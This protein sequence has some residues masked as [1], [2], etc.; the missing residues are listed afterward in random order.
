M[1]VQPTPP[2]TFSI[3]RPEDAGPGLQIVPDGPGRIHAR[4]LGRVVVDLV[5][6]SIVMVLTTESLWGVDHLTT[7]ESF[8]LGVLVVPVIIANMGWIGLYDRTQSRRWPAAVLVVGRSVLLGAV[9]FSLA[10]FFTEMGN[11]AR[12]WILLVTLAWLVVLSLHHGLRAWG[13]SG[14]AHS[15]VIVAGSPLE[16]VAMRA[17]LRTDR[18]HDYDVVGFVVNGLDDDV[19]PIVADMALGA[20]ADLPHLVDRY[21]VDQVMFCMGGLNGAQFAPIARAINAKGIAVSLTGLGNVAVRRVGLTHV[22]GRP[23]VSIA[24]A[25]RAGWRMLIKRA[26]DLVVAS[27]I[28]LLI[29]PLLGAVALAIRLI[30]GH[31]P[32]FKQERLGK[33]GAPFD[34]YKFR[35]MVVDAEQLTVDLTNDHEGPVFKM[36]GDPRITKVGAFIRKTSIDELPQLWNVLRGDMS[37]VGPRPLLR[38]EVEAAPVS[39]R[40]REAVM[41]GM[42]GQWQVSGRSDTDFDQLDELD[43]WYVDNWSL[44]NDLGILAKTVPAV[45]LQRGAR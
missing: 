34:I 2:T 42:T 31:S 32:I 41:P 11:G 12:N 20:I 35:S 19:P 23:V 18:R 38:H 39:F 43:R 44:S 17:T 6:M 16:A 10:G 36:R 21:E 25:V 22:Q 30:D 15:R 27:A 33:G 7:S 40:D 26:A 4:N 24:P 28:L 13:R 1:T 5:L 14:T 8:R 3:R 45:L 9:L 29:S 37:L